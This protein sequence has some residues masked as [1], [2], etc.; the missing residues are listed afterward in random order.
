MKFKKLNGEVVGFWPF[1]L[2]KCI[3]VGAVVLLILLLVAL[4]TALCQHDAG[5]YN[6]GDGTFQ[7]YNGVRRM[8]MGQRPFQDF[9]FYL[10]LGPLHLSWFGP[11]IGPNTYL[12][13]NYWTQFI[14]ALCGSLSVAWFFFIISRRSTLSL[15]AGPVYIVL[16][17]VFHSL[18]KIDWN[19]PDL[20]FFLA[21]GNSLRPLRFVVI[22]IVSALLHVALERGDES[23]KWNIWDFAKLGGLAGLSLAWS[24]D[25]GLASALMLFV[26][27]MVIATRR[28]CASLAVF[29]AVF[30]GATYG[31]V[32]ILTHGAFDR[33]FDYLFVNVPQD[34]GWLF[35]A[36]GSGAGVGSIR[37][38][39]AQIS[40][41]PILASATFLG[42]YAWYLSVRIRRSTPESGEVSFDSD[43]MLRRFLVVFYVLGA[44]YGGSAIY[45]LFNSGGLFGFFHVPLIACAI[46]YCFYRRGI[47]VCLFPPRWEG[48]IF[49]GVFAGAVCVASLIVVLLV[50]KPSGIVYDKEIGGKVYGQISDIKEASERFF[51]PSDKVFSTY[52]AAYECMTG[53]MISTGFDYIIHALGADSR[54]EYL[55][56]FRND[57][58]KFVLLPI[59]WHYS[60]WSLSQFWWFSKEVF[61]NYKLVSASFARYMLFES[62]SGGMLCERN[63]V[64]DVTVSRD[65]TYAHEIGFQAEDA[66]GEC[67][68]YIST[69]RL[70]HPGMRSTGC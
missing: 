30:C 26:V 45:W 68:R 49:S 27:A 50:K 20:M 32:N 62:C 56:G 18:R 66:R 42:Y 34:Q 53:S 14:S 55:Q 43:F 8:L 21:A 60:F 69:M 4:T 31:I 28:F 47:G 39:L 16:A 19:V 24:T 44:S 3:S 48:L 61:D 6:L 9:V 12:F 13:S 52:S 23:P 33:W 1:S 70:R 35:A 63:P 38:A 22:T 54:R 11:Y 41:W 17:L 64:F 59:D 46:A 40:T 15:L 29:G 58:P 25:F 51:K 37:G 10:G 57:Q 65:G 36:S 2:K 7:T 5:R 67:W